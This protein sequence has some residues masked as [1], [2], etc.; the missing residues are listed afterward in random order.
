M[1]EEGGT[2]AFLWGGAPSA[3]A[4]LPPQ[5][6]LPESPKAVGYHFPMASARKLEATVPLVN[7]VAGAGSSSGDG[8]NT[9]KRVPALLL[10]PLVLPRKLVVSIESLKSGV[11]YSVILKFAQ[12]VELA[13]QN[14]NRP[15][16]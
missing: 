7:P 13:I 6:Q 10:S 14:F 12:W 5:P 11:S 8:S 3:S 9:S 15:C 2:P 1:V 16:G 4:S